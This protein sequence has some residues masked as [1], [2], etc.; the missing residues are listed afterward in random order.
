MKVDKKTKK[1]K[2]MHLKTDDMDFYR[3]E[4]GLINS[5]RM[6]ALQDTVRCI[7]QQNGI[8]KYINRTLLMI[9]W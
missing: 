1:K 6:K 4:K 2:I 9:V 3:K 8:A 5:G 7:L